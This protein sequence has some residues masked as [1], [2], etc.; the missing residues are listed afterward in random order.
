MKNLFFTSIILL[1]SVSYAGVMSI[2]VTGIK[3]MMGQVRLAI[4]NNKESHLS[5]KI[6][7]RTAKTQANLETVFLIV[8]DMPYGSYSIA[9][10]HDADDSG[11]M[12]KNILGIPKEL[13][14][15]SNGAQTSVLGAPSFEQCKINFTDDTQVFEIHLGGVF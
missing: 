4:Y 9:A 13:F 8:E 3:Q 14:G 5:E 11:N 6:N 15:F 1:S 12:T 7:F 2:K 10:F